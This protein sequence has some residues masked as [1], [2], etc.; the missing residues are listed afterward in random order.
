MGRL[1]GD[2]GGGPW[3]CRSCGARIWW[4]STVAG[5]SIP[6]DVEP[7]EAGNVLI[8]G[9]GEEEPSP[10]AEVLGGVRLDR[11]RKMAGRG[12]LDLFVSHFATCPKASSWRR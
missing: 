6:L 10:V 1:V 11:A 5:K 7:S 4:A 8:H 12:E 9:G 3:R 2:S